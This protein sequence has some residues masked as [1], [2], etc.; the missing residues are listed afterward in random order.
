MP[1]YEY[2]CLACGIQFDQF[3][4]IT[5]DP[6]QE[7]PQCTG[8]VKRLIGAGAALIFKGSGFY[9]TDYRSEN[10]KESEKKDSESSSDSQKDS[11]SSDAK[12]SKSGSK[13]DKTNSSD[14]SQSKKA[15]DAND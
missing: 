15:S 9:A 12:S 4:S 10:Y 6:L 1:T 8:Q 11:K 2:R 13:N 3:Q 5:A 14:T 7:C